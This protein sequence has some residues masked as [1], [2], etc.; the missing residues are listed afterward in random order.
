MNLLLVESHEISPGGQVTL[1]DRRAEHLVKVLKVEP[2]KRLRV[3]LVGGSRGEGEVCAVSRGEVELRVDIPEGHP[4]PARHDLIVAL[5]RPQALHRVL[6]SAATMGV[7]RLDLVAAWRVEKSFF[8]TPSLRPETVHRHLM[9]GAEQGMVTRLP[10]V[11]VHPR[12]LPFIETLSSR[13]PTARLL[14][15]PEATVALESVAP[16]PSE[17]STLAIGPEGGWIDREVDTFLGVGFEAVHLGR[18][19]LKVENAVTAMLAQLD[20]LHRLRTTGAW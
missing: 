1:T 20:L 4:E 11:G 19:I 8:S 3:G 14:A 2:G 13:E 18:W 5:P 7:G 17:R 10:E 16:K 12:F 15:H 6:Q 9:L